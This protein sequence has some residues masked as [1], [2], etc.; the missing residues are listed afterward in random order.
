MS[1]IRYLKRKISEITQKRSTLAFDTN[2]NRSKSNILN[3]R[4]DGL[5]ILI[6]GGGIAGL[7]LARSCEIARIPYHVFEKAD[8]FHTDN[9]A[10]TGIGL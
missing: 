9:K 8:A 1:F 3:S 5:P 6:I 7:T 4:S 2:M 10:G